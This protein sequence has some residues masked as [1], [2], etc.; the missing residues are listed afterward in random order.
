MRVKPIHIL[1]YEDNPGYRDSFKL[2]AQKERIITEAFDNVDNTLEALEENPRK[3]Q[4]VVLDA[5]AY[6]HEGQSE[7]T[8]SEAN[9]HKIFREIQKIE[10]KQDRIIPYCIN[11]GF[12]EVKL[13]YREVLPCRIFEKGEETA[14]FQ[15]I[16]ESYDS[17][18]VA[19]LRS[20][21]PDV[22][23]FADR[24][25]DEVN[26]EVLGSLLKN[27]NY[28]SNHTATKVNNLSSLRRLTEH[29]MDIIYNRYLNQQG[30][31][32]RGRATRASDVINFL[33][34]QGLTPSQVSGAV[35][36]ILKTASNYGSHTPEQAEQIAGYP[37]NNSIIGLTF[38][39]FET[40]NWTKK[41]L[42]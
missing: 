20:E 1:L 12:A 22:F 14:L 38:G 15:H 16:W 39:F 8:E 10:K 40:I 9:L 35:I 30:G 25:F 6:L 18:D 3:H 37:T 28:E 27:K 7:G 33:N 2:A 36:N 41:I 19:K 34:N 23:E 21:Y 13:Q 29:T 11:T 4:F 26:N 31:I 5:R 42:T 17:S 32:I 24:Y